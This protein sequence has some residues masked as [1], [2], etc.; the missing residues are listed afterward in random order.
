MSASKAQQAATAERRKK[1]I[2]LKLAGLDYQAIADQLGYADRAA[3][4]IDIDRALKKNLAEEA[5]QVELLRHV[6]VQQ[7][8][9]L[10]AAVWPK[11]VKGDTRAA[12][13][14]LRVITQR[15]K[16]QGVEAPTL[17]AL[18]HRLDLEGELVAAA[19]GAALDAVPDL[20]HETRV[21]MLGAAQQHLLGA[22]GDAA[23]A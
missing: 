14:A 4:W 2:A 8:N 17:I 13:T 11:A 6:A 18:E 7:L 19:L 22:G 23:A 9:R 20:P 12:E 15:C 16:L 5:E 21:A 3:A 1:A 10:Q